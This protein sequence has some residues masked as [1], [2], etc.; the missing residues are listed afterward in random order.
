M[1]SRMAEI[2]SS[3]L[4]AGEEGWVSREFRGGAMALCVSGKLSGDLLQT[5]LLLAVI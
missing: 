5:T 1:T 2:I 3:V 4:Y